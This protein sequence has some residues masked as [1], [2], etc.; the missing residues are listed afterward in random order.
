MFSS[1]GIQKQQRL[2]TADML[3]AVFELFSSVL[4]FPSAVPETGTI[5][6]RAVLGTMQDRAGNLGV[7][8]C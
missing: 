8:A 5:C 2:S 3:D 1:E 4:L 7:K 6:I